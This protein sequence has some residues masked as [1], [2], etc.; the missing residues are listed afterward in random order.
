EDCGSKVGIPP[1]PQKPPNGLNWGSPGMLTS[2]GAA[3]ATCAETVSR[4]T[5]P[6]NLR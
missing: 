3:I 4:T 2:W 5:T 1:R 6:P